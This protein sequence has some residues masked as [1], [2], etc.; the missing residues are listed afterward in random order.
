M[1]TQ[2]N[3]V[4]ISPAQLKYLHGLYR[5][6]G[7][8]EEMYREM[9]RH[10]FGVRSTKD[11]S[12]HQ[13]TGYISLL[14]EVVKA[15]DVRITYKQMFLVRELWKVIDYS[16][17]KEGDKHLNAFLNKYYNRPCLAQ[18]TKGEAIKLIRQIKEMTKQAKARAGK[19]TVLKRR[20]QCTRCGQWIMWVE[21]KDGRR[22]AFDCDNDR[23]PTNFHECHENAIHQ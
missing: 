14:Q 2:N 12:F 8:D 17:G 5:A 19:T 21:L 10:H 4:M 18:L 3:I 11:L 13:A 23:N 6:L 7:W 9:L 15:M 16:Q 22:E 1:D 20:T